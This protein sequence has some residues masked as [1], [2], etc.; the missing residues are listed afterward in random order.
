M[1]TLVTRAPD[2]GWHM[3][4][5]Q[6]ILATNWS[7]PPPP[8]LPLP[9]YVPFLLCPAPAPILCPCLLLLKCFQSNGIYTFLELDHRLRQVKKQLRPRNRSRIRCQGDPTHPVYPPERPLGALQGASGT[10]CG[11]RMDRK[12]L[13]SGKHVVRGTAQARLP[14]LVLPLF[15]TLKNPFTSDFDLSTS[16]EHDVNLL[17]TFRNIL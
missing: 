12:E 2:R 7:S 3:V 15:L 14:A 17:F 11:L 6:G 1:S 13:R 4:G 9:F 16:Q 5:A 8:H 10:A